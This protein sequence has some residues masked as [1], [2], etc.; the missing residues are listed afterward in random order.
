MV[1]WSA[2]PVF[3]SGPARQTVSPEAGAD[4]WT[5]EDATLAK[6]KPNEPCWCGSGKKYKKCHRVA[7]LQAGREAPDA[8]VEIAVTE[9]E[10]V[11]TKPTVQP[12]LVSPMREV[13]GHIPRPS[14]ADS[15]QP[16]RQRGSLIKTPEVIE[17]MRRAGRAAREILEIVKAQVRPGITTDELDVIA[18]AAHIER[19]GYPSPL[20]Y[21]GFPKSICTSVNEVI[22][23]GIPDSRPL[24]DGDIVN[25][26]VTIFVDGVHG[27]HS[28]T[29]LVGNVDS[30]AR[31]LA[32]T[33]Y[34]CMMLG[35]EAIRPGGKV[36]DIGRAIEGHANSH[37]FSVVRAFVGH[38]IGEDFH[39]DPQ[40][41]HYFDSRFTAPL[42]PGM[43]FT[44]EP[45]I[46]EGVWEHRQ[47]DDNWTA[48][49]ADLKRSAQF[50]HTVLVTDE[51]TEIL[52][53]GSEPTF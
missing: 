39:T 29:L 17:R 15:G 37:G 46:N 49:T 16:G 40:V 18:H 22:C 33:A 36:R 31:L 6:P 41:A 53:E 52:T 26:D 48:V 32:R 30:E 13:P 5:G 12:G 25:V 43:T 19:G 27:D 21:H 2:G 4:P 20:N 11:I 10:A 23:H 14:Y 7:D 50:E 38:G 34:E 42:R 51:G 35:I 44:V 24:Q 47:W 45:M 1:P 8:G 3:W 28:E 9:A